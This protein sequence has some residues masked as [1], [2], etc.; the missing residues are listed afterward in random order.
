M[1][2][3]GKRLAPLFQGLCGGVKGRAVSLLPVAYRL[4]RGLQVSVEERRALAK[5]L[6]AQKKD[7][8][9]FSGKRVLCWEPAPFP[10]HVAITS[11]VGTALFLRGCE[12]EQVICDGTPVACIIREVGHDEPLSE[13]PERCRGCYESCRNEAASFAVRTTSLGEMLSPDDL[14]RLREIADA[15]DVSELPHLCHMDVNVGTYAVSSLTRYYKGKLVEPDESLLREFLYGALVIT[16]AA[17]N[18][19]DSFKPDALY[20]SHGIYS[21][22]GP[23]LK[24]ALQKGVPV[25]KFGGGYLPSFTY[26]RKIV[27]GDNVHQGMLSDAGW[28]H[29]KVAPLTGSEEGLLNAYIRRRYTRGGSD[30]SV[31]GAP[32]EDR[33][34]MVARLRLDGD[35]PI[36][37]VFTNVAW[38]A[39]IDVAPMAFDGPEQ[40]LVETVKTIGAVEDVQWLIKVH[41]SENSSETLQGAEDIIRRHFP[42]LPSNIKIIPADTT[43]N[44]YDILKLVD[45]GVTCMGNTAGLELLML[46]KPMI[47]AGESIFANRGFTY[48]GHTPAEYI[49]YLKTAPDIP[50]LSEEQQADVFKLAYSYFI[51]RQIPLRMFET[52][53]KGHFTSFDWKKVDMLLPGKDPVMDMICERFFEGEDFIIGDDALPGVI[54][55]WRDN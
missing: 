33:D 19:I 17:A 5:E 4:Q 11:S 8:P 10:I 24:V 39:S 12:V 14:R 3:L 52:S 38:D 48:D 20:M 36:W 23:A 6:Q 7:L 53:S 55:M 13:W 25:V 49:E 34:G 21:S 28:E 1:T 15:I 40:W 9:L 42:R 29:R 27:G 16:E 18:K 32:R 2:A 37:C 51:Q 45:G 30:I 26:I 31:S 22:W 35:R 50:P 54:S 43:L 41:P 44:T 46:G 47:V